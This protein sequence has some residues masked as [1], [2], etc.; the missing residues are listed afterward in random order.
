MKQ[1]NRRAQITEGAIIPTLFKMTLPMIAGTFAFMAFNLIDTYFVG[2]LGAKDLAAMSFTFPVIFTVLSLSF[3]LG[4]GATAL[5]SRAIGSNQAGRWMFTLPSGIT[6]LYIAGDY[7][8]V[9]GLTLDD[10]I[11][12]GK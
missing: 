2:Q 3:G 6:S 8:I 5:V 10:E 11:P 1:M 7:V 4:V 12:E 9:R